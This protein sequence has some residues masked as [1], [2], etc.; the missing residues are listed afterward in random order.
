[1]ATY[2]VQPFW[3]RQI[4]RRV[5]LSPMINATTRFKLVKI[6]WPKQPEM[7]TCGTLVEAGWGNQVSQLFVNH[8]RLMRLITP[9]SLA[10]TFGRVSAPLGCSITPDFCV[11]SIDPSD[12]TL[13]KLSKY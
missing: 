2:S 4:E 9:S 13:E 11:A 8:R 7:F 1:M 6:K 3:Q 10:A 5:Q 12:A